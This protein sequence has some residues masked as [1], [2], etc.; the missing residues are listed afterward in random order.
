MPR[1]RNAASFAGGMQQG[2]FFVGGMIDMMNRKEDR[3]RKMD[4]EDATDRRADTRMHYLRTRIPGLAKL[5][6]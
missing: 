4:R 3:K 5:T 6:G 2:L 1:Y